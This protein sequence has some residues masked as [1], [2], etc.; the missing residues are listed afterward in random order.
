MLHYDR[1][2][3][4]LCSYAVGSLLAYEPVPAATQHYELARYF[5]LEL[6]KILVI[7]I[8]L[9]PSPH[10]QIKDS[11]GRELAMDVSRSSCDH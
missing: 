3:D 2:S 5:H 4:W 11:D 6:M 9:P 7:S 1:L 8:L 10:F